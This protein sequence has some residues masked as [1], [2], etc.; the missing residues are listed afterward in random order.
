MVVD[1]FV[2]HFTVDIGHVTNGVL[3]L[4]LFC[5]GHF[6]SHGGFS[7]GPNQTFW[8]VTVESEWKIAE[9]QALKQNTF[10]M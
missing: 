1:N 10:Y 7:G 6:Q 8:E 2:E 9:M 3:K 5:S 4:F